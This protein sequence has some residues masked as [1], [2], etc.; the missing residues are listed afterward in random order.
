MECCSGRTD[1][2]R[3]AP[4]TVETT[5]VVDLSST[6]KFSRRFEFIFMNLS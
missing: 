1:V 5:V 4:V 6:C 2:F 3:T